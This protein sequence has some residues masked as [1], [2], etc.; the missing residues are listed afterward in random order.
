MSNHSCEITKKPDGSGYSM[1][2]DGHYVG[3]YPNVV[4]AANDYNKREEKEKHGNDSGN[5]KSAT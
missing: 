5:F 4:A 2:I 3:D 1:S